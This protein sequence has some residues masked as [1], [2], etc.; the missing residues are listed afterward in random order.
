MADNMLGSG[1]IAADAILTFMNLTMYWHA[2]ELG[3]EPM[4]V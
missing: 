3:F 2:A 1:D 4:A